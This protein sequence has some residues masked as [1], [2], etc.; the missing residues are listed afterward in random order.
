MADPA[1]LA[2][3]QKA[4]LLRRLNEAD[5]SKK[6]WERDW[7]AKKPWEMDWTKQAPVSTD[8]TV[9][10]PESF[11]DDGTRGLAL[12]TD[13]TNVDG[14]RVLADATRQL[15][16]GAT[17]NAADEIEAGIRT[18]GGMWGDYGRTADEI[19]DANDAF[20]ADNPKTTLALQLMGGVAVPG[21]GA[22]N[23][24]A[25]GTTT[26]ARMGR[27]AASGGI[28][29]SLAGF[30]AGEN[31]LVNRAEHAAV[32][33]IVGTATGGALTAGAAALTP[34]V[35]G[36]MARFG[37]LD[38]PEAQ[39][40]LS[41]A[42]DREAAA[43]GLRRDDLL[44]VISVN[45]VPFQRQPG[46]SLATG[47]HENL[48]GLAHMV[49]AADPR[50]RDIIQR[51]GNDARDGVS[52]RLTESIDQALGGPGGY[53]RSLDAMRSTREQAA[54][55]AYATLHAD[56]TRHDFS[57]ALDL[58]SPTTAAAVQR[59]NS[60]LADAG[61]APIN[62]ATLTAR[63]ADFLTRA[64]DDATDQAFASNAS[65]HGHQVAALRDRFR[66]AAYQA[67]PAFRQ[68]RATYAD[69][70][71]V[72]RALE[73][74]RSLP[75]KEGA[76]FDASRLALARN[77]NGDAVRVGALQGLRDAVNNTGSPSV[78]ANTFSDSSR[79]ARF[80]EVVGPRVGDTPAQSLY[81]S[82]LTELVPG[83]AERAN[84]AQALLKGLP[85][86]VTP[87]Q[88]A[89]AT[90]DPVRAAVRPNSTVIDAGRAA[91]SLLTNQMNANRAQI[92]ARMLTGDARTAVRGLRA[93]QPER[94]TLLS[95]SLGAL[96][97]VLGG[98]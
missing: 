2:K 20:A 28:I 93:M 9:A 32:G 18:G 74:G 91:A 36:L 43:R 64:L 85:D 44:N 81:F 46:L 38:G 42:V 48:N 10:D 50:A 79:A 37:A 65:N 97:Y 90:I 87:A 58:N 59:V 72:V 34:V 8:G 12:S 62:G 47:G 7:S 96:P 98:Q 63:E 88:R 83:E 82:R 30:N 41:E 45:A 31:G 15:A 5:K 17:L 84:N 49:A 89:A 11:G 94:R 73:E 51:A 26:A 66:S 6:P 3:L 92:L 77:P 25:R 4:D 71:A 27:G 29:G 69:D 23:V 78:W 13:G 55:A 80:G 22:A 56:P 19:R 35:R 68:L 40:L 60:W 53:Q 67:I 75:V 33:G 76:D 52:Q 70:S 16:Q 54:N 95:R 57:R 61:A 24:V 39:R 86:A 14:N 21:M 1:V